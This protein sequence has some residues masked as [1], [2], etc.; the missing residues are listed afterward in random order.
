MN[1]SI[2]PG[3]FLWGGATAANQ[4]EG[5]YNEDGKGL[6]ISDLLLGGDVDT[7]RTI[8]TEIEKGKF[9][10]SH[11]AID[12]YHRYKEDVA[13]FAEM[14]FKVYRFSIAWS[15]IYPTGLENEPNE[16]GLRFYDNLIAE[17][18]K[19]NIEP[20]ITIS[21][22]ESPVELTRK[23]NGWESRKMIDH[24]VKFATTLLDRYK[25]DV[26]YWLTFNEINILS[27]DVGVGTYLGGGMYPDDIDDF[28]N[29][30]NIDNSQQRFQALHHQFVAS[31]KVV[32]YARSLNKDL[33]MGCM[34]AYRMIY[35][36]TSHPKDVKFAQE[37]TNVSNFYCGDVQV[38]GYYP[39]FA[40]KFWQDRNIKIKFED[41]DEDILKSGTVDYYTFSYYQSSTVTATDE[42]AEKQV[43]NFFNG[44]KN[45]YL[46]AS[47]WGWE[48]D[49]LG[50]RTALN[51]IYERYELPLMVVEN[52]LGAVDELVER[53]GEKMV[54]DDY[55]ID[56]LQSHI[57]AMKEAI[58]E[59]VNLVGYT[60]WGPID[61]VS[62]GTGQMHKRY[63]YIYVDKHD[64]GSGDLSRYKKKSFYWY[65]DVISTNGEDLEN[66]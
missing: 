49:P 47:E 22:Y 4:L 26:K 39:Y 61:L 64:D 31:A 35:P 50:L 62:A 1:K 33:H 10:P 2:F 58:E 55:R 11:E 27:R 52:G 65:K 34:I 9:Y 43:G 23:F 14:G 36:L 20:M 16:E 66:N 57:Q 56:Y 25:D 18:K 17:L 5:A 6:S 21:H 32:N 28:L 30:K 51:Q 45:P 37:M 13:L 8:T 42:T 63:G 40:K 53:S 59:G 44:V 12:H 15:R 60:S 19:Y 29:T 54:D 7:P 41:G 46:E 24:Y 48:I 38:K 3:N